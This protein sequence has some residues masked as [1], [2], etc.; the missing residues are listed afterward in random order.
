MKS[1]YSRNTNTDL[2]Q[3]S[4]S[5]KNNHGGSSTFRKSYNLEVFNRK[6]SDCP[7]PIFNDNNLFAK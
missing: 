7:Y 6:Q 1:E 4:F 3:L 2:N 5:N